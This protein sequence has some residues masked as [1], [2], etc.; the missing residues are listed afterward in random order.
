MDEHA[1]IPCAVVV[2]TRVDWPTQFTYPAAERV[3][4]LLRQDGRFEVVEFLPYDAHND[5]LYV[6]LRCLRDG[7]ADGRRREF[8][9][10]YFSAHGMP[11]E[12]GLVD[13]IPDGQTF[14]EHITGSLF[15]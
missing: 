13:V 6:R 4:D 9:L 14:M 11:D 7:T 1:A 15:S 8:R 12:S 3:A 5:D 2:A 10:G